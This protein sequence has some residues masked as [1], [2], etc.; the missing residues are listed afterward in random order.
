MSVGVSNHCIEKGD[1]EI[2]EAQR[3]TW[4]NKLSKGFNISDVAFEFG[5]LVAEVGE[6]FTSW[7]K[8]QSDLGEELADVAIFVMSIA[9]MCGVDLDA[10]VVE[11]ITKNAT[12][13]YERNARGALVRVDEE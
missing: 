5:L 3:L 4:D 12:R 13:S 2:T 10:E 7:R 6:A 9:E 1:M 8:R 11:K